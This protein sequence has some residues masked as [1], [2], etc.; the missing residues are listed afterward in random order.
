MVTALN[1]IRADQGP[2]WGLI[3]YS[4]GAAAVPVYLSNVPDGTFQAAAMF[5]GYLTTTHTGLL[6]KVNDE[7]PF[8]DIPALIWFSTADTTIT[9]GLSRGLG[10]KFTS[11][12]LIEADPGP[13]HIPPSC[14]DSTFNDVVTWFQTTGGASAA[15]GGSAAC[16]RSAAAGTAGLPAAALMVALPSIALSL[17]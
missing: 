10:P 5:C 13:G 2:F 17:A 6:N 7:A 11:P 16:S 12:N 3:G 8:G 14:G 4:Q 9:P 15:S 1:T